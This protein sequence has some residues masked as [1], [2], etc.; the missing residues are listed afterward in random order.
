MLRSRQ[1]RLKRQMI[2]MLSQCNDHSLSRSCDANVAIGGNETPQTPDET[3]VKSSGRG[4]A[5]L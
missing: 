3:E 5:P 4:P 2:Y 1:S